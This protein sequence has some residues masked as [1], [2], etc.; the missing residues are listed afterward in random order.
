MANVRFKGG[1]VPAPLDLYTRIAE[2]IIYSSACAI[3]QNGDN[4]I[5]L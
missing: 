3:N 5:C 1:A 2:K 4:E